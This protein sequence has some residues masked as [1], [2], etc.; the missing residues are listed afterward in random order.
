[1]GE[2]WYN[3]ENYWGWGFVK[4]VEVEGVNFYKC[5][6]D[7]IFIDNSFYVCRNDIIKGVDK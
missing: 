1:M 3:S 5:R 2:V 4:F 6:S 7:V